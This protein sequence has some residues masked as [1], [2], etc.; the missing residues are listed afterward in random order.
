ML[1]DDDD[2]KQQSKVMI[3]KDQGELQDAFVCSGSGFFFK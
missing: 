2:Y 1:E 3:R